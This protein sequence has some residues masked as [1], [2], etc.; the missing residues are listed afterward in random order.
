MESIGS[1]HEQ[2][3]QLSPKSITIL[4]INEYFLCIRNGVLQM[5]E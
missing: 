5:S 1:E 4:E 2:I 3:I